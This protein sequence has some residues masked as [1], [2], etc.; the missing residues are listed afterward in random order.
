MAGSVMH[1]LDAIPCEDRVA[2]DHRSKLS[3]SLGVNARFSNS[4]DGLRRDRPSSRRME[5][6]EAGSTDA[7]GAE[8]GE[9]HIRP[10]RAYRA[11]L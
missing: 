1:E 11:R 6:L 7:L 8:N 5:M 2:H 3:L 9:R 4:P 10:A